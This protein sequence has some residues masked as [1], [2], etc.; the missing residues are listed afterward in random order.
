[1]GPFRI[2]RTPYL[3][4][5]YQACADPRVTRV[6][7]V[8]SA[9][10]GGTELLNNVLLYTLVEEPRPVLYALPTEDDAKDEAT[11]R[12][13][14]MIE[15]CPATRGFIPHANFASGEIIRLRGPRT[16]Y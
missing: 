2:A 15:D 16:I 1:P 12:L 4:E 3:S 14:C 10:V 7:L 9:Q 5:P 6:I 13:R 8:K 11:G